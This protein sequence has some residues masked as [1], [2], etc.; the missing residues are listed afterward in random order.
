MVIKA[1][2]AKAKAVATTITAKPKRTKR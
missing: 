1:K 2:A